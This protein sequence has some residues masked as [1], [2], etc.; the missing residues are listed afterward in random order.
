M[1]KPV[2]IEVRANEW[3]MRAKNPNVPW[4]A[5]D[6]AA[7]AEA[8]RKAGASIYHFHARNPDGSASHDVGIYGAAIRAIRAR[9]DILIHPTLAGV[10]TPEGRDRIGPVL[11]LA[12]DP[13]THPDFAPMDMGSTNLDA[14]DEEAKQF[15]TEAKTYV[16]TIKTLSF[17]GESIRNAGMKQLLCV[18]TVPCWRAIDAFI[19]MDR[20]DEPAY[21]TMVLT[22]G[23]ILGGHPGTVRGM[24][25]LLEFMPAG[26]RIEWS[27]CC[28]EGNLFPMAGAALERGGHV[29]IGLGD[30]AYTELGKPT[31]ADLVREVA[32][33]AQRV[34]RTAATPA[35]TRALLGMH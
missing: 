1:A 11:E 25:T 16:N 14:Y 22:D 5:E 18:W 33:M 6:F 17:L 12:K 19:D 8:C 9:T 35:E 23:G 31:N 28:R 2:I 34:G 29:S 32:A 13:A 20:I 30:Y 4:T 15:T 24:E 3:S 27:V 26:R 10:I 7:D 21:A